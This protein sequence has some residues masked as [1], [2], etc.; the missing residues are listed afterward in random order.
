MKSL[1]HRNRDA[2]TLLELLLSISIIAALTAVAIPQIAMILGDRRLV[3]GADLVRI[4]MTELRVEAMRDGRVMMMDAMLEDGQLRTRP[5]FSMADSVEASDATGSQSALLNGA[6]SGTITA[7]TIDETATKEIELPEEITVKAVATVSAARS[8][9]IEQ[10]TA[11]EQASGWSSPILFYPDGTTSN[12]AIVL[13]HPEHG[14]ITVKLRGI[15]GEVNIGPM[16][17]VQ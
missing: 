14:Q 3:R 8:Y 16:E 17:A 1:L 13:M 4:R 6:D 12:A 15:T 11:G 7:I 10:Q 9:D 5:Y 2:F